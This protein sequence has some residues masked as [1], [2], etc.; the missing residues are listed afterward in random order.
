[1]NVLLR[2]LARPFVR[3]YAV[4]GH[5]TLGPRVHIGLGTTLWAPHALEVGEDVYIGKRCTIEADGVIG[6]GTLVAND[7]GIVGRRDHDV[8]TK[9]V[10]ARFAAWVGDRESVSMDG[11]VTIGEDV[12]IGFGAIVLSGVTVGRGAL[13]AAG[14][15]VTADVAPYAVVAGNPARVVGT[16]F[17]G[18]DAGQHERM[19]AEWWARRGA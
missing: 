7:V 2:A 15:V 5:V 3:W 13:V 16:R 6:R 9:G 11:R 17:A 8:W 12:W 19:V 10:P 18:A 4:R 1:M 14:A